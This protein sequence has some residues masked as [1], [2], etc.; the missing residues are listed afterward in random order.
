MKSIAIFLVLMFTAV[1]LL[2][3]Q[4]TVPPK[5]VTE[6]RNHVEIDGI[7]LGAT[8]LNEAQLKQR[9]VAEL[10]RD[11]LVVEIAL[12]PKDGEDLQVQPDQFVLHIAGQDRAL[13]SENPKVIAASVQRGEESKRDIS[14]VPHADV[15]Y[16]SGR[17]GYDPTTGTTRSTGGVYTSTGVAVILG[18]S[19]TAADPQNEGVMALELSE[20]AL[21]QGAFAK[22][23]SGHLY[24]RIGKGTY[25]D[26]K[27]KFELAYELNGKEGSLALKR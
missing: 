9:F 23:V 10:G 15:G 13:R 3:A 7:G 1:L 4:G 8:V 5:K 19:S 16:E 24:F 6:L 17:R 18:T 21:P 22:P 20:K 27:A 14:I 11:Y 26:T 25:K 12:F 2:A